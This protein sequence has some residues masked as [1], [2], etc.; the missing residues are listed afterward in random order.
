MLER[1]T[2]RPS[3]LGP[4]PAGPPPR[5]QPRSRRRSRLRGAPSLRGFRRKNWDDHVGDLATMAS[6]PGFRA[7]RD[8][9]VGLARPAAT[10]VVLDVGAGTGLLTLA[11]APR[12]ARV[13]A[14]DVSGAMCEYLDAEVDRHQLG[15]VATIVSTAVTVPLPAASVDLVVSNYCF[16][17]LRDSDK[18]RALAEL[19]RVLR[20]GGR[21]VFA[22]M[23]FRVSIVDRRDRAV[24][25]GLVGRLLRRG[26]AGVVRIAKNAFRYATGRWEQP[27]AVGWWEAALLRAGFGE[28]EVRPLAHE[29]GIATARRPAA[30]P[31][32]APPGAAAQAS[33]APSA[34][35]SSG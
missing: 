31:S 2:D 35:S 20:P 15:N 10:D 6:S 29:G 4:P 34:A 12:V 7:L 32:P 11:L 27:A 28:V 25:A 8:E 19:M 30:P 21:L 13:W 1:P 23:M 5:P 33:A 22:D 14:L 9:I 24:I 18:E 17:H 26:P 3:R 16:H